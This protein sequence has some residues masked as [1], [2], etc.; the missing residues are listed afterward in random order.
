MWPVGPVLEA[1][2]RRWIKAPFFDSQ[3]VEL[4]L[5]ITLLNAHPLHSV[6]RD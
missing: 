2:A 4:F 5:E 3:I 1:Q 6:P